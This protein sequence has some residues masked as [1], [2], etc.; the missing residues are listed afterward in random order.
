MGCHLGAFLT[1]CLWMR[2]CLLHGGIPLPLLVWLLPTLAPVLHPCLALLL[3]MP[4]A[5]PPQHL[6]LRH[7]PITRRKPAPEKGAGED[8]GEA[9]AGAGTG[10]GSEGPFITVSHLACL[11]LLGPHLKELSLD[12]GG[13][14]PGGIG[15]DTAAAA[16]LVSALP[17]LQSLVLAY[18]AQSALPAAVL[19]QLVVGLPE[20]E[21]LR[22]SVPVSSPADVVAAGLAAEQQAQEGRR[23]E[24][25]V[26]LVPKAAQRDAVNQLLALGGLGLGHVVVR[27]WIVSIWDT[28][29]EGEEEGE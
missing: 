6:M 2:A 14:S 1:F 29:S 23:T 8:V 17:H 9:G 5:L 3:P 16:V 25:L 26:I 24:R 4:S 15:M 20:L 10:P 18:P 13:K 27:K 12:E 19:V 28:D 21:L 11:S 22:L 7:A